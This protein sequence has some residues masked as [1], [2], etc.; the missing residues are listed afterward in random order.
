MQIVRILRHP[1]IRCVIGHFRTGCSLVQV[2]D[3]FD[4]QPLESQWSM[5]VKVPLVNKLWLMSRIAEG[6]SF[7]HSKGIFHRNITASN[8]MVNE[9]LDD[10]R[11]CEFEFAKDVDLTQTLS[12]GKMKGRDNRIL[13]PE[14]FLE[15]GARNM[16]YRLCD[17]YQIG[18]LFYRIIES[19]AWPFENPLDYCTG[20]CTVNE[21][22]SHQREEGFEETVDLI[23]KMMEIRPEN[24]PDPM[25]EVVSI[26]NDIIRKSS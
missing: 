10:P 3:W 20:Q 5:L 6:F 25:Q 19:G 8:I 2:S 13:P 24:R 26:L 16:N 18:I 12:K 1:Y 23:L 4:G 9:A 21:L 17:I 11:I 22:K 15:K 14:E 7:C